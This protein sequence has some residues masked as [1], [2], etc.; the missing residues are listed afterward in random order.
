[1][2]RIEPDQQSLAGGA[3]DQ[4]TRLLSQEVLVH[5]RAYQ[6]NEIKETVCLAQK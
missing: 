3:S 2:N 6:R 4:K 1:M 5:C